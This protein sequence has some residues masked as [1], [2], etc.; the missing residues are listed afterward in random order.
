MVSSRLKKT[1]RPPVAGTV[2]RSQ[3]VTTYGVGAVLPIESESFMVAGIDDWKVR[4][5]DQIREDRLCA[6]LGASALYTPPSSDEGAMVPIVRFPEWVSCQRCGRLDT[7][8]NLAA[9]R[10]EKYLSKCVH[11]VD[12][13]LIPSRFITSC[14]A[15]HIQDFPYRFWVHKAAGQANDAAKH[16]LKIKTNAT[17]SSLAGILIICSCGAHRSLA[18]A[19]GA[20]VAQ[21]GCRG[22]TPWLRSAPIECS[23]RVY[24]L[25]R[26][27]SNVWFPDVRSALVID[28]T[29]T[30]SEIILAKNY[31]TLNNLTLDQAEAVLRTIAPAN[32]VDPE[33][34]VATYLKKFGKPERS[35]FDELRAEEYEALCRAH[36]EETGAESFVCTPLDVPDEHSIQ[37]TLSRVSKVSRLREV[38]ALR[39]FNRVTI[40]AES[41]T[42][43]RGR[44]TTGATKWLPAIEVL[45]EG[46]FTRL[47]DAAISSWAGSD[48]ARGRARLITD[49]MRDAAGIPDLS[50]VTPRRLLLHSIAHALLAELALTSGYPESSIRE[51]IYDAPDQS[52]ILLYTATADAAGGLGGLCSHASPRRIAEIFH[53]AIEHAQWCSADPVCLESNVS[54][55]GAVNLAACH[56]C[57]LLPEVSCEHQ[58]RFL[59]R[60]SLVGSVSDPNGGFFSP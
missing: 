52:G 36:P 37:G 19:L 49:A 51:R 1:K 21:V 28:R 8:W 58:N 32:D 12:A 48:F 22:R 26:G 17:D 5:D 16:S 11:C 60:A 40:P 27:A 30:Q 43:P 35:S 14:E 23:E 24:G 13:P 38:R 29:P 57:M 42:E 6:A 31:L 25:Q 46:V 9:K 4:D 39:G 41:T 59:D 20:S 53:Q 34:L 56:S 50:E 2:R 10:D 44:L 55:A 7:F 54:G 45:G 18:G 33:A 15:G 47:D 3:L